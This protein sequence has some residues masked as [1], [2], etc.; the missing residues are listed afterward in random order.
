[1]FRTV[2]ESILSTW[3]ISHWMKKK[4]I[5]KLVKEYKYCV[6]VCI[7][8][9]RHSNPSTYLY[10]VAWAQYSN[11]IARLEAENSWHKTVHIVNGF[12][13]GHFNSAHAHILTQIQPTIF[14]IFTQRISMS[15]ECIQRGAW[16]FLHPASWAEL[17]WARL[18]HN[19][20]EV[21]WFDCFD[22]LEYRNRATNLRPIL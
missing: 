10:F 19:N 2:Q 9:G 14:Q 11:W 13:L 3:D 22:I 4:F 7:A 18:K 6:R 12:V 15:S 5:W 20:I 8:Y 1:M 17:K 16:C 21:Y